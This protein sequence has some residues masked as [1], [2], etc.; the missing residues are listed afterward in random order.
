[1]RATN[2]YLQRAS[3][4]RRYPILIC[5]LK[6]SLYNFTDDLIEMVDQRL[7]ELYNQAQRNFDSDRLMASKT[8]DKKLKTLQDISQI[9][10]DQDIEDNSVRAKTFEYIAPDE[11]KVSLS[12]TKQ[13]IRPE[14]DA[15]VDYFGK[16]YNRVRRF[17]SKL[18]NT[19]QFQTRGND[20]R[21]L[22]AL[23]LVHEIHLGQ[24]RKLPNDAP[25]DF[26]PEP[27]LPY[28]LEER[29]INISMF[30]DSIIL[31]V[32]DLAKIIL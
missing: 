15:Y 2:Q 11:L 7:W 8:I 1:M 23:N 32:N 21:L 13:L 6:Q 20:R 19:L 9:L 31:I 4:V 10:L 17:S 26:I 18:L 27:W 24:R 12:E 30:T 14:N 5:F 25:T 16:S 29:E 3:T 28:V 22:T